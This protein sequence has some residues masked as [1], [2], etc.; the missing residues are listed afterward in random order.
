VLD[1]LAHFRIRPHF[2]QGSALRAG[3]R[4]LGKPP[5]GWRPGPGVSAASVCGLLAAG[6]LLRLGGVSGRWAR[7]LCPL[8]S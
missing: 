3:G 8:V 5:M 6:V 4:R 7:R 2:D 1:V